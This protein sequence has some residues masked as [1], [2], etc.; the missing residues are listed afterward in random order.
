MSTRRG[1]QVFNQMLFD[2]ASE[3]PARVSKGRDKQLIEKRDE[4]LLYR[5]FYKSKIQRKIYDDVLAEL[6]LEVF[7]SPT[8]MQKIIQ[9]KST[10]ALRI[11]KECQG[12]QISAVRKAFANKFPFINWD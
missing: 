10:Q 8:M 3:R 9:A 6:E 5:F 1:L 11:K 4:L 7:L 12:L 2:D